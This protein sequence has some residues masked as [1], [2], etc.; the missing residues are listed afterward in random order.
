MRMDGSAEYEDIDGE[1]RIGLRER[2]DV[3]SAS[4]SIGCHD[5]DAHERYALGLIEISTGVGSTPLRVTSVTIGDDSDE[6]QPARERTQAFIGR[7]WDPDQD[8]THYPHTVATANTRTPSDLFEL[9]RKWT[10]IP[11]DIAVVKILPQGQVAS[12]WALTLER[13]SINSSI[14]DVLISLEGADPQ[15]AFGNRKLYSVLTPTRIQAF[16]KVLSLHGEDALMGATRFITAGTRDGQKALDLL[17]ALASATDATYTHRIG[18]N[19]WDLELR[20]AGS[21]VKPA[22][23]DVGII[24]R[25]L[26]KKKGVDWINVTV[27]PDVEG[28]VGV[29]VRSESRS[30]NPWYREG[31]HKKY[32]LTLIGAHGNIYNSRQGLRL[33]MIRGSEYF[34]EVEGVPAKHPF[35]FTTDETGGPKAPDRARLSV[36]MHKDSTPGVSVLRY[37]PTRMGTSYYQCTEHAKMGGEVFVSKS[38]VT[39]PLFVDEESGKRVAQCCETQRFVVLD[40]D[41]EQVGH[42]VRTLERAVAKLGLAITAR[43]NIGES[44]AP[45]ESGAVLASISRNEDDDFDGH[46]PAVLLKSDGA[47]FCTHVHTLDGLRAWLVQGKPEDSEQLCPLCFEG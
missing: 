26:P 25:I 37:K 35:H 10:D 3:A 45:A 1:V 38:T 20:R 4:A 41:G 22:R 32:A 27:V 11:Q 24:P 46:S 5:G 31:Y 36:A 28:A 6:P 43:F 7:K 29:T 14:Y 2:E 19:G 9:L 15:L 42:A 16:E 8:D 12:E 34:F 17:E 44:I 30:T 23:T 47:M 13:A 18:G 39:A 21:M 40:E 33:N